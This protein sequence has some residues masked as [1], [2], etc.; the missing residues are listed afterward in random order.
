[1][2]EWSPPGGRSKSLRWTTW[3]TQGVVELADLGQFELSRHQPSPL[4]QGHG[5]WRR[6][7]AAIPRD[8][9]DLIW[10]ANP[11][12]I[13]LRSRRWNKA[14]ERQ[15][16]GSTLLMQIPIQVQGRSPQVS[17]DLP[18]VN[19]GLSGWFSIHFIHILQLSILP[20]WLPI[21]H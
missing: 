11:H 9:A 2:K 7:M 1:M 6:L 13:Q 5:K 12:S 10:P 15:R 3:S 18:P 16:S 17:E 8:W 21:Q 20:F 14:V 19:S 4:N